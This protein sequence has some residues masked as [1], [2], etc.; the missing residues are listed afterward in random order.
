[1][2]R[3]MISVS[4]NQRLTDRLWDP[5]RLEG[6]AYDRSTE[7]SRTVQCNDNTALPGCLADSSSTFPVSRAV[8]KGVIKSNKNARLDSRVEICQTIKDFE[9]DIDPPV[10]RR[11]CK[12]PLAAR[13]LFLLG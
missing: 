9:L 8:I 4:L 10:P 1:M 5:A 6:Q 3:D 2:L 13:I 7:Q 12:S 11:W